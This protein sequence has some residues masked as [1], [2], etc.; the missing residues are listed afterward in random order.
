MR[1]QS[2]LL[3]FYFSLTTYTVLAQNK[4]EPG[5][6]VDTQ[7]DTLSG[8]IEYQEWPENPKEIFFKSKMESEVKKYSPKDISTFYVHEKKYVKAGV[9]ADESGKAIKVSPEFPFHPILEDTVFLLELVPGVK[10]LYYLKD[11]K[12]KDHFYIFKD[13][14]MEWLI[15]QFYKGGNVQGVD[16]TYISNQTYKAQLYDYLKNCSAIDRRINIVSYTKRSLSN[17]FWRFY[18]NCAELRR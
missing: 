10:S 1:H 14:Q 6:I 17:I 8:Y 2:A 9:L 7:K 16:A 11:S 3:L 18:E 15:Y 12:G 13:G 5:Y 4:F